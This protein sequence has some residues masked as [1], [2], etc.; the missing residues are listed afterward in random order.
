MIFNFDPRNVGNLSRLDFSGKYMIFLAFEEKKL[1]VNP[2][3][4]SYRSIRSNFGVGEIFEIQCFLQAFI[5][6]F[7]NKL[8]II[9]QLATGLLKC[10]RPR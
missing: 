5:I 7:F 8:E 2:T 4:F 9:N 10:V 6:G 3:I 1:E